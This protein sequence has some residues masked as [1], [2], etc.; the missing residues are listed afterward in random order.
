MFV[1]AVKNTLIKYN[2]SL[3]LLLLLIPSRKKQWCF[4]NRNG[5]CMGVCYHAC[6]CEVAAQHHACYSGQRESCLQGKI[7]RKQLKKFGIRLVQEPWVK[8]AS[9]DWIKYENTLIVFETS[10][11]VIPTA[12]KGMSH[13]CF[14]AAVNINWCFVTPLIFTPWQ[15]WHY[16]RV[17]CLHPAG[18]QCTETRYAETRLFDLMLHRAG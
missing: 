14:I 6:Q 18:W 17:A 8:I 10:N 7:C 4:S 11:Q 1:S 3:V 13:H 12:A 16:A 9:F 2:C 5:W 15:L